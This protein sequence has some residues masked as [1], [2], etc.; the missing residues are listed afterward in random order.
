M[1]KIFILSL[2]VIS[3]YADIDGLGF[4]SDNI[5]DG[6]VVK[7][8]SE[9]KQGDLKI[10]DS[11]LKSDTFT[12]SGSLKDAIVDNSTITQSSVCITSATVKNVTID[13]SSKIDNSAKSIIN[14]TISQSSVYIPTGSTLTDSTIKLDSSIENTKIN[15]SNISLCNLYIASGATVSNANVNGNCK[16]KNSEIVGATISQGN[17]IS[18]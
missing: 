6:V 11:T 16:L 9:V 18:H 7:N 12:L 8:D 2:I 17:V 1:K 15:N 5:I 13:N 3:T 10:T 14:S 4:N